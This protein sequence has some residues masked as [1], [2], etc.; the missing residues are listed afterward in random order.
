LAKYWDKNKTRPMDVLE[1]ID[2]LKEQFIYYDT[3]LK[4]P[5]HKDFVLEND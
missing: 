2:A 5:E 1:Q 4:K 3:L